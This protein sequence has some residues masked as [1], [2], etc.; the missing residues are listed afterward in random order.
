MACRCKIGAPS[1]GRGRAKASRC[2][3]F[4][5]P[6]CGPS[7]AASL[8]QGPP[9]ITLLLPQDAALSMGH[10]VSRLPV[11][12]QGLTCGALLRHLHAF[13]D[14]PLDLG[15]SAAASLLGDVCTGGRRGPGG[16]APPLRHTLLG[17]RLALEGVVRATRDPVGCVYEVVL[18]A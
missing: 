10:A 13:Y 18:T 12:P 9:S 1:G 11:P 7:P 17:A 3:T 15:D 2:A 5:Q 4:L 14:Q 16:G 8:L 6:Y